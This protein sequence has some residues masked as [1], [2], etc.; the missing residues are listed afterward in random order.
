MSKAIH[1]KSIPEFTYGIKFQDS[2]FIWVLELFQ[3]DGPYL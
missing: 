1:F 3:E 2:K